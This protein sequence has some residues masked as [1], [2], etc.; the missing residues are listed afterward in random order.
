MLWLDTSGFWGQGPG[1]WVTFY[2]KI[3]EDDLSLETVLPLFSASFPLSPL[4]P[5]VSGVGARAGRDREGSG[6][7]QRQGALVCKYKVTKATGDHLKSDL[8]TAG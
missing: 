2:R 1:L 8:S 3:Q 7:G 6:W 5:I 4:L